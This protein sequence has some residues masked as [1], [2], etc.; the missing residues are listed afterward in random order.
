[1][2]KQQIEKRL[3]RLNI[4]DRRERSRIFG[5]IDTT[6]RQGSA[7]EMIGL[8]WAHMDMAERLSNL[9]DNDDVFFRENE[10]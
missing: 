6:E 10:K 5:N 1:M 7:T 3:D 2:T 4:L 8:V 9:F